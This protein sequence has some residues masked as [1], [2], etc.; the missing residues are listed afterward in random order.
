[1]IRSCTAE[2]DL[3]DDRFLLR[4]SSLDLPNL[5][6]EPANLHLIVNSSAVFDRTVRLPSAQI[7]SPVQPFPWLKRMLDEL[8]T[9]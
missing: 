9:G 4:K 1:M 5:D 7:S 2:D 3:I 6:P 8:L